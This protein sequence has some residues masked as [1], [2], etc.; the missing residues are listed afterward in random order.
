MRFRERLLSAVNLSG[1]SCVTLIVNGDVYVF[2][3]RSVYWEI[4]EL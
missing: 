4:A 2:D 1:P 3:T